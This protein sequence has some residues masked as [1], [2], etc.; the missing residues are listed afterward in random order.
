ME[1]TDRRMDEQTDSNRT[2]ERQPL[3]RA[4]LLRDSGPVKAL[5]RIITLLIY[6]GHE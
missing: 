4:E 1:L 5:H 2:H 6:L 3:L